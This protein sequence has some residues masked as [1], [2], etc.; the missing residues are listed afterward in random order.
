M[1][2]QDELRRN[3]SQPAFVVPIFDGAWINAQVNI[4]LPPLAMLQSFA[5]AEVDFTLSCPGS[6][7]ADC[8]IWDHCVTLTATCYPDT[9][10]EH[11]GLGEV[12]GTTNE[13]ARWITPFRRRGGRWLTDITPVLPHLNST[14]CTFALAAPD[15]GWV[16]DLSLRFS[17]PLATNPSARKPPLISRPLFS[18]GTFNG[19]YNNR[20]AVKVPLPE[21]TRRVELQAVITGHGSDNHGCCEFEQTTH[22]FTVNG[23]PFQATF[24]VAGSE[25]GCAS[26]ARNG[27]IPN[28]HGTWYFGRD[29]WCDGQNVRPH[30]WDVTDA[31][32][33]SGGTAVVEYTAFFH[34]N[35]PP[36]DDGGGYI[37]LTSNLVLYN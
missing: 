29:G 27:A 30:V 19:Q 6:R 11:Q 18:G 37:L 25:Y 33:G 20:S 34:A 23:H 4:S 9:P 5:R 3:L 26:E 22:R 36:P 15:P 7:D 21:G 10:A 35:D 28:E 32:Q 1:D 14:N 13:L 8:P 24:A 31:V 16:G 17:Q 2:Y 12:G